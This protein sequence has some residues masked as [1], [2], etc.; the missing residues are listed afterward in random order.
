MIVRIL[1]S[2]ILALMVIGQVLPAMAQ[3]A[4]EHSL[5]RAMPAPRV[6]GSVT[7]GSISSGLPH[8]TVWP[9]NPTPLSLQK[10]SVSNGKGYQDRKSSLPCRH[11]Y[12][13]GDR[14]GAKR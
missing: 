2:V 14:E 13:P 11:Q 9:C 8:G 12:R 1:L 4:N 6:A 5:T 7:N 10:K 3:E